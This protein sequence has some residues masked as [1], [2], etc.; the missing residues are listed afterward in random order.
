[1]AASGSR[2]QRGSLQTADAALQKAPAAS[3]RVMTR[4]RLGLF[5]VLGACKTTLPSTVQQAPVKPS[6]LIGTAYDAHTQEFT[7]MSCLDVSSLHADDYEMT[8]Q[9]EVRAELK[10]AVTAAELESVFGFFQ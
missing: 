10:D 5:L 1:C 9:G 4:I 7:G 3:G 8:S 6:A 2:R